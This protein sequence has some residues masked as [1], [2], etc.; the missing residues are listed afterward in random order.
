MYFN[1]ITSA[2]Y[3]IVCFAF[4]SQGIMKFI[5]RVLLFFENMIFN[6]S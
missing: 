6:S 5:Q 1:K 3:L 4:F 2:L